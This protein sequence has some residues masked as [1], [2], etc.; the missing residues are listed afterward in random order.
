[1]VPEP[2]LFENLYFHFVAKL[3]ILTKSAPEQCELMG[4][5]NTA[6]ELKADV[7]GGAYLL[8]CPSGARFTDWQRQ[9]M[10]DL[11]AALEAV[12]STELPAG[13]D[14]NDNLAAMRHPTWE[15]LRRKSKVLLRLLEP[16][17]EANE[18][19][20]EDEAKKLKEDA[21][22]IADGIKKAAEDG[23]KKVED[24]AKKVGEDLKKAPDKVDLKK[25]ELPKV[26]VPKLEVPKVTP[27]KLESSL[28]NIDAPAAKGAILNR[29]SPADLRRL[30]MAPVFVSRNSRVG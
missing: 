25:I 15:P 9:E 26:E 24:A 22:K 2:E 19:Y 4:N 6:W 8:N 23:A 14:F 12:P 28:P 13:D 27:P 7:S 30:E 16:V 29:F 18:K 20:F 11:F 5:Y 1:M 17:T 3:R 10:L 21:Q